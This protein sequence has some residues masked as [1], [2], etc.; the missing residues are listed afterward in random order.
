MPD[1][2]TAVLGGSSALGA[3]GSIIGGNNAAD[4][5]K[6]AA[7]SA[8]NTQM[9][10]FNTAQENLAP[11]NKFGQNTITNLLAPALPGL[12]APV[13]MDEATLKNTPG[14]Q[15][16]LD[17]GLQAIQ[18]SASA[19]GLGNSGAAL[20]G[21]ATFASGLADNTYQNQFNNATANNTNT[22]NKLLQIASLGENAGAGVGNAAIQTGQSIGNNIIGAGNAQAASYLNTG[23][24]IN[25]GLQGVANGMLTNQLLGMYGNNQQ[26]LG[27]A[28]P[29]LN[30]GTFI[31]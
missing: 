8:T 6:D 19:R 11:Y 15:F 26:N 5:Q 25:N 24:S 14:Y 3:I 12:A 27:S 17:Q 13:S 30:G 20:K 1:P 9:Q 28:M 23:N 21:A 7:N 4:A 16:N 2:I 10:M 18:N 29:W 31:G 22:F